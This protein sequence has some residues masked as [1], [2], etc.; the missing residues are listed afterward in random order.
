MNWY[1]RYLLPWFL[2]LACSSPAIRR[3][4]SLIVPQATGNVLEVGM[5]TGLNLPHYQSDQVSRVVGL[6]PSAAM[7]KRAQRVAQRAAYPIEIVDGIAEDIP[8]S[9]QQYDCIVLTYTLCTIPNPNQALAEMRRVLR[10]N[11]TLLFCEHGLAP[12]PAVASRQRRFNGIWR[13][14]AGGCNLDRDIV[15]LIG[16]AG[17]KIDELSTGYLPK[18]PK[19]AG[20]QMWGRAGI[21]DS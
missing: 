7:R 5:G 14:C 18:T 15:Q 20:Y 12:E 19:I 11:G 1:E 13:A 4:R 6:E 10:P 3:Q 8:K 17:F 21:A 16:D 9:D 2:H